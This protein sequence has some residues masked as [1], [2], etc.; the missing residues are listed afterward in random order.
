MLTVAPS[1][2][3]ARLRAEVEEKTE[4]LAAATSAIA[5]L[6]Q[7]LRQAGEAAGAAA[8]ARAEVDA[9]L[10]KTSVALQAAE[11][12]C[13][14][15]EVSYVPIVKEAWPHTEPTANGESSGSGICTS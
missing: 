13:E 12:R 11:D 4:Q 6:E 3:L 9:S 15:A 5:V 2:V 7:Q 1:C 10:A 8:A 14:A